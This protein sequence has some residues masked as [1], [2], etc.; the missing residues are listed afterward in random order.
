MKVFLRSLVY[1]LI[2]RKLFH[3]FYYSKKREINSPILENQCTRENF[4]SNFT[5]LRDYFHKFRRK[6]HSNTKG[7]RYLTYEF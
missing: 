4:P 3:C 7:F 6:M 2:P 5:N 1:P